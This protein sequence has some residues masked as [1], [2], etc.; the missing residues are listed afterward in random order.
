MLR[1]GFQAIAGTKPFST[2]FPARPKD[3][4][5]SRPLIMDGQGNFYG[6][7]G[8]GAL[9]LGAVFELVP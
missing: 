7:S 8:G 2:L 9:D 5:L 1:N 3:K 4:I 6:T